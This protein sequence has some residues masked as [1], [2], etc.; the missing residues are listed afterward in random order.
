[1][2]REQT[3]KLLSDLK[4]SPRERVKWVLKIVDLCDLPLVLLE[5][6]Y[7]AGMDEN[8]RGYVCLLEQVFGSKWSAFKDFFFFELLNISE[9]LL[10]T[11]H[12]AQIFEGE[13]KTRIYW[14]LKTGN[15]PYLDAEQIHVVIEA[16]RTLTPREE[17]I[18][19]RHFGI[20]HVAQ[21][22][23]QIAQDFSVTGGRV[24]HIAAKALRK[25]RH[26]SRAKQLRFVCG[27]M[28]QRYRAACLRVTELRAANNQ[29]H[30][31]SAEFAD[32]NWKAESLHEKLAKSIDALE[33]SVRSYN[34]LCNANIRT[35]GDLVSKTAS[36]LRNIKY[37]GR[38]SLRE[39]E[40]VLAGM[41]LSLTM[42]TE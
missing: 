35:I 41:G 20:G 18:L 12:L 16:L 5:E 6:I 2:L 40:E 31:K 9:S 29:L 34:C 37:F 36:E 8:L 15:W 23:A 38:K 22:F 26:P 10:E 19:R 27:S 25:L 24:R 7:N 11:D 17:E 28:E 42:K 39:I 4:L 21:T 3:A 13:L 14:R 32:Q 33:I 1:M 30:K